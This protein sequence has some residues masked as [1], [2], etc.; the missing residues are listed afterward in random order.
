MGWR[1]KGC[2]LNSESI[3]SLFYYYGSWHGYKRKRGRWLRHMKTTAEIRAYDP[4]L[5]RAKRSPRNLPTVFDDF[6]ISYERSWKRHR[7]HQYKPL[8]ID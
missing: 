6:V 4:E 2:P 3:H 8:E 1:D 5:C 7:L